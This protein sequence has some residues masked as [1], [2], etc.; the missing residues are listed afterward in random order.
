V[1]VVDSDVYERDA[2]VDEDVDDPD[3]DHSDDAICS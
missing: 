3:W 2:E 1:D